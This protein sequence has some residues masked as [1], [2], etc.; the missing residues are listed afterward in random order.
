M[1]GANHQTSRAVLVTGA[2]RGLARGIVAD[3]AGA[4]YRVAFTFRP[5]G[6]PPDA[7]LADVQRSGAEAFAIAC[8]H[9]IE[10]ETA[11]VLRTVESGFGGIDVL[12]H[13]VGPMLVRRFERST[14]DD[15]HAMFDANVRS[16]VEAASAVLPSMRA[17]RFGRL[18]FFGMNGSQATLPA[19]G[20]SLYA[21]AKAAV[22]SFARTVALEEAKYGITVNAIEP[23]D[24]R[25]KEQ[26]RAAARDVPA[27]NPTGHAGSWEDVAYAVRFL[28]S[29]E[30]SFINGVVVPVSGGLREANE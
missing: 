16:A 18:V 15:F 13:A 4:G 30:A 14:L 27:K 20:L 5:N 29:D 22:V 23:G 7:T 25:E 28:I 24:I 26:G 9:A 2:A 21:A 10:G 11:K 6:T 19:R 8:D 1:T 17:K 12:V 3:L